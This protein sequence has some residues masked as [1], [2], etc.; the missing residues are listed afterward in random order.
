M[1]SQDSLFG[2]IVGLGM[3]ADGAQVPLAALADESGSIPYDQIA[4]L[5]ASGKIEAWESP[6]LGAV[7]VL[8][9]HAAQS[10]GLRL[11]LDSSRWVDRRHPI[12]PAKRSRRT[13]TIAETDLDD[14]QDTPLDQKEDPR[15]REAQEDAL[16][17]ERLDEIRAAIGTKR[18]RAEFDNLRPPMILMMG[19]IAYPLPGQDRG[20]QAPDAVPSEFERERGRHRHHSGPC[21]CCK[22]LTL[23]RDY[24]CEPC[25]R[26]WN[27]RVPPVS[28]DP[29]VIRME[30]P[31]RRERREPRDR[32]ADKTQ[33]E[34]A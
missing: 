8:T 16:M 2:Q 19:A 28:N 5:M 27:D 6:D 26:W 18:M 13:Q 22:G 34:V 17:D 4:D 20:P 15:A 7:V 24:G 11:T 9:P 21:H 31:I 29:Q 32:M 1:S 12:R 3:R 25:S 33:E 30:I 10:L 14:E 23:R